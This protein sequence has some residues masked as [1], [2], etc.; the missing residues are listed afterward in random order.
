VDPSTLSDLLVRTSRTYALAIPMLAEP[1]RQ[2]VA[3]AYLLFRIADTFEDAASWP[4]DDRIAAL[5]TFAGWLDGDRRGAE[6]A[7]A[8]WVARRPST[9][10]GYLD[11]LRA[12]RGV[13]DATDALEPRARAVIHSHIRRTCDGMARF[14]A[15]TDGDR[16]D[17][18]DIEDL[19]AYCYVVAGI[20]G[21]LL[22]EL[23]LLD[24][25]GPRAHADALRA[26]ARSFGEA[27]QLVNILKDAAADDRDGRSYLPPG[28]DRATIFALA[29]ADL[30]RAAHHVHLL[31]MG[32]AGRDYVAFTA[33]PVLL[34]HA[35]L[36]RIEADGP[37][38]KVDRPTVLA[39]HAGLVERLER[40]EPALP[41]R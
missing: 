37:G 6:A 4:V 23:V 3:L 10:E 16:L 20:V 33:L 8:D 29:R 36:E 22:T 39:L 32:A 26:D 17:L 28:V 11:L 9:H 19:R 15:R 13:L 21:E 1:L 24:R 14:V 2:Q 7:V 5:A 40:G 12:T 38:A 31:E 34:A 18:V 41:G 30:D 35:A 25:P 27:L